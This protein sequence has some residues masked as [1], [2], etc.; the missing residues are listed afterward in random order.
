MKFGTPLAIALVSFVVGCGASSD[1]GGGNS[2]TNNGGSKATDGTGGD[3]S[4]GPGT[5]GY[6]S[7]TTDGGS[8]TGGADPCNLNS[9]FEGDDLC[10]PPPSADEGIQ[11][12]MGPSSYD[13][14]NATAPYMIAAGDENV[15][16][17][18]AP[19]PESDF[20]YLKQQNRMRSHSH[21]MLISVVNDATVQEGPASQCDLLA[22]GGVSIPGSQTPRHDFPDQLGPEDSG[23]G[24]YLPQANM[25]LFQMH[26]V[27]T[28]TNPVLREAWVNL[29]K[30][31]AAEV[32]TPLNTIFLVGD[33][34]LIT[35]PIPPHTQATTTIEY[36]PAI[37]AETRVFAMNG[38]MHA[39]T[40]TF[41]V[42]RER[43]TD[44][45]MIYKTFNWEEPNEITLN[46]VVTNPTIDDAT[47]TGGG[48]S[49]DFTLLPGDKLKWTCEVDN[50]LDT[51]LHFANQALTAEMCLLAGAYIGQKGVLTGGCS[52]G[53]VP[54]AVGSCGG[55]P[56]PNTM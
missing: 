29:Y 20:Y 52:T 36:A 28:T 54:G 27:N 6:A 18:Y 1:K 34:G 14:P 5:G 47:K 44:S 31:P 39:H 42:W 23:I 41:T 8:T 12:H 16:C 17:F 46:S 55:L 19:I 32:T 2:A 37:T 48:V 7:G 50:T 26:Y 56:V 53:G 38:H 25:A 33:L 21:H 10:V 43:G 3:T 13:D 11:I 9:G 30:K 22:G 15:K 40:Q 35:N 45:E 49:G 4:M 51:A 24:R